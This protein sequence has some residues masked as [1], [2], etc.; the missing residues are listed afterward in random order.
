[1]ALTKCQICSKEFYIKPSHLKLGWGKFCSIKCRS[2]AQLKGKIVKCFIC[3]K[4]VYRSPQLLSRSK[5]NN[6]FCSKSCQTLWRNKQYI[7]DKNKNWVNGRKS[8]RKILLRNEIKPVCKLCKITDERVLIAHHLD[9]DRE[10]NNLK[11]LIWLYLNCHY[12]IHN[13]KDFENN[14]K[15]NRN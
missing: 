11:N 12:L 8:Y 10:N 14:L 3:G 4:K 15:Y 13:F 5:S 1:M 6:F 7:E 9:H 2:I